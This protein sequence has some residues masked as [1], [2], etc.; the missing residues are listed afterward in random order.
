VVATRGKFGP[1]LK[2]G[3]K[4]VKLPRTADPLT[5]S[6]EECIAL[7]RESTD[8]K[9]AVTYIADF[10]DI[11]VVNGRYGPYIKQGTSNFKIPRGVD[12]ASLT[13]ADCQAIIAGGEPTKKF[14]LK[15]RK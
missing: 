15:R 1:Y 13:E 14:S 12:A 9:A 10:G 2:Y 6:L 8:D 7:I 11:K 3:S 4:N 5:I